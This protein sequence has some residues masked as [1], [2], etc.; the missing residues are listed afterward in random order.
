MKYII[1]ILGIASLLSF[2]GVEN[3]ERFNNAG[4]VSSI[5]VE[6]KYNQCQA[7]AKSTGKQCKHCVSNS[8]DINCWQ[9]K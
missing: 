2:K 9:H 8:G 4:L 5:S 7:T 3:S 1:F 6:C